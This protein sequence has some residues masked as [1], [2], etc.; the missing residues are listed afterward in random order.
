MLAHALIS[1][2]LAVRTSAYQHKAVN[3]RQHSGR[4]LLTQNGHKIQKEK[5]AFTAALSRL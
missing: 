5:T 1:M 2:K 4:L 3:P